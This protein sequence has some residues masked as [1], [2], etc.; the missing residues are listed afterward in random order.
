VVCPGSSLIGRS[1]AD[2]LLR[3]R[4]GI[5]LLA[6][7]RQ[8]SAPTR[9]RTL[10][11]PAGDVLLMQGTP[12]RAGRV[13]VRAPAACRWPSARCAFPT[14]ARRRSRSAVMAPPSPSPRSACCR[15]PSRSLLGVLASMAL[16]T[17]P[18]R[19][20]YDAIDWPV[21]VLLAALIP[22]AGAMATR[23]PQI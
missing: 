15:R 11:D 8:G 10:A 4:F 3:T 7:S 20:V 17:V 1:A 22:V 5:N 2:I 13:R 12:A 16:R 6:V 19:T 14:R 18:P 23:E 21:I 9:L